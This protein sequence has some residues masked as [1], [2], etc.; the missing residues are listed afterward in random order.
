MDLQ[1]RKEFHGS[2]EKLA[3]KYGLQDIEFA[4]FILQYGFRNKF[5]ASDIVFALLAILEASV[6]VHFDFLPIPTLYMFLIVL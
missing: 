3:E 5:C 2:L 6:S 1:L 4:S